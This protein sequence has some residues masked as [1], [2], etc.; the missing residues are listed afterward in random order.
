MRGFRQWALFISIPVS[1]VRFCRHSHCLPTYPSRL[2]GVTVTVSVADA[3]SLTTARSCSCL[4]LCCSSEIV[5]LGQCF[6]K[7]LSKH[8]KE[9]GSFADEDLLREWKLHSPSQLNAQ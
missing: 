7:V 3:S 4:F 8:V 5:S 6:S 1:C 2:I 9:L